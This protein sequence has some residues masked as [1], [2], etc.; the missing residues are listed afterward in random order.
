MSPSSIVLSSQRLSTK[1]CAALAHKVPKVQI[2]TLKWLDENVR[3]YE[4]ALH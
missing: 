2:E 3:V 4:L 1:W